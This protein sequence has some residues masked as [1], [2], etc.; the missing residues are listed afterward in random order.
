MISFSG[1]WVK[2]AHVPPTVSAFYR[3]LFGGLALLLSVGYKKEFRWQGVRLVA[4]ALLCALFF[5][6]DLAFYHISVQRVGPGLGTILP[7]FQV[8]LLTAVAVIWLGEPLRLRFILSIPLAATGL[9]M[10]VGLDWQQLTPD[11]RSGVLAGFAAAVCYT[12]FLLSLRRIQSQQQG[13]TSAYGLTLV[14][15][16]TAGWLSLEVIRDGSRFAI[17]DGQSL[18]ALILLGLLSQ[19]VGWMLITQALPAIRASIAGLILLLQPTL[20]FVWD[21][22]F[23]SRPTSLV[24]WLGVVLAVAAIHMGMTTATR[25]NPGQRGERDGSHTGATS[26]DKRFP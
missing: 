11:Y 20:A 15:L 14:S 26:P 13:I 7:N 19:C 5:A 2:L 16:L 25:R 18:L 9:M 24:N 10:I 1:V 21:V 4:A 3:V 17:P 22:L 8:V 12:A 23:F 6:L